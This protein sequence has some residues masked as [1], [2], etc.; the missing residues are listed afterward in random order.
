LKNFVKKIIP[1]IIKKKLYAYY[2]RAIRKDH[3]RNSIE[4]ERLIPLYELAEIHL[5]NLKVLQ[6]AMIY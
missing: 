5:K 3:Y 1:K 6:I 4:K 2:S